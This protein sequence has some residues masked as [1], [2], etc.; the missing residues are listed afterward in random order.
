MKKNLEKNIQIP[1]GIKVSFDDGKISVKGNGKE[2]LRKFNFGK[3]KF[4]ADGNSLKLDAKN[5]TK[6]ESKIIGTIA[7]HIKNM[8]QGIQEDFVYKME[9]CNVHFP[10]NVKLDKN[11]LIIK[12]FL[13][14]SVDRNAEILE[15]VKVDI[16]GNEI[17]ISSADVEKAG[18]TATNIERATKL[19]G[20]DRRI[21]QDGIFITEKPGRKM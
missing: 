5:A 1:E 12:S 8:I 14:E 9:I 2:L 10:M 11:K 15:N 16:K 20:R 3:V 13:G 17:V 18:Q 21:F 19:R 4:S 6:R 7:S